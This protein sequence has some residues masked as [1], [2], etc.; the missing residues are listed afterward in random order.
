MMW[1]ISQRGCVITYK[2]LNATVDPVRGEIVDRGFVEEQRPALVVE[3]GLSDNA[4]EAGLVPAGSLRVYIDD[5]FDCKI[6]DRITYDGRDFEA[7]NV[8]HIARANV[9]ELILKEV[10]NGV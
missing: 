7:S 5:V 4:V 1:A 10:S 2:T 3:M 6:G 9:Y 8:N